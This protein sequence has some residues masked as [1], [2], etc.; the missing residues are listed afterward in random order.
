[1]WSFIWDLQ[2]IGA[3]GRKRVALTRKYRVDSDITASILQLK[4]IVPS[5]LKAEVLRKLFSGLSTCEDSEDNGLSSCLSTRLVAIG[6]LHL[7]FRISVCSSNCLV[8]CYLF[9]T[10][11]LM[12]GYLS[13]LDHAGRCPCLKTLPVISGPRMWICTFGSH[14]FSSAQ[15]PTKYQTH[16]RAN[17]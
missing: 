4:F 6:F 17:F 14:L 10:L 12:E 13:P 8:F 11:S 7:W 5:V 9:S 3:S 2:S 15:T 1:M 16:N